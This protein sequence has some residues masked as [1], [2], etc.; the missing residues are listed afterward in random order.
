MSNSFPHL[1]FCRIGQITSHSQT[2]WKLLLSLHS[3]TISTKD[4]NIYYRI[5]HFCPSL[6]RLKLT[7]DLLTR[8]ISHE[9]CPHVSLRRFELHLILRSIS[10]DQVLGFLFAPLS[11]LTHLTING[12]GHHPKQ[13]D[14]QLLNLLLHQHVPQLQQ[15]YLQMLVDTASVRKIETGNYQ[16]HPLFVRMFM[17]H[18]MLYARMSIQ[19]TISS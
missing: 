5:L 18:N 8:P 10:L 11:N 2:H 13:F 3:L 12:P 4:P 15:F 9:H 6:I 14:I 7:I 19:I 16:I 17:Y 1:R